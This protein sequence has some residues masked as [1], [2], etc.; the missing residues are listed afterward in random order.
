M[1]E[2]LESLELLV[3]KLISWG[4]QS[5][6]IKKNP[7]ARDKCKITFSAV[8]R[9]SQTEEVIDGYLWDGVYNHHNEAL[10]ELED[11]LLKRQIK[12]TLEISNIVVTK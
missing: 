2:R 3:D 4:S 11:M 8:T 7:I 10:D 9:D 5:I 1:I 12:Y 6:G